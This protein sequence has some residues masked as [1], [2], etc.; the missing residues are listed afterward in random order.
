[1]RKNCLVGKGW[2]KGVLLA[3][4]LIVITLLC[5]PFGGGR[6]AAKADSE[7]A[8]APCTVHSYVVNATVNENRTIDFEEEIVFTMHENKNS[9]YRALPVEGDRF[10]NFRAEG[11]GNTAFSYDVKT[12]E[13]DNDFIDVNCYGGL[14]AGATIHY[15]FFYT[16]ECH[17]SNNGDGMRVDFV[18]GG[19]PFALNNVTVNVRFPA[20][21]TSLEI[22]SSE[23]LTAENKYVTV[24]EQTDNYVSLYAEKLPLCKNTYGNYAAPI[25][26]DF[27][28]AKGGLIPA[29]FS[30]FTRPTLWV[31]A[32]CALVAIGI[33][34]FFFIRSMKRPVLSTVV[35]FTAPDGMDP[36]ELGY[37]LDGVADN[38]D[39]TAMV[40]YFASKGYLS[41]SLDGDE[42]VL[43]RVAYIFPHTESA[44]AKVLFEGLF[45]GGRQ[46]VSVSELTNQFYV[47]SNRAKTVVAQKKQPMYEKK[48][49]LRFYLCALLSLAVF[50]LVPFLTGRLYVGKGYTAMMMPALMQ[51]LP[52]LGSTLTFWSLESYRYKFTRKKRILLMLIP[53]ALMIIGG[54]VYGVMNSNVLTVLERVLTLLAGYALLWLEMGML[55]RTE[56]HMEMLGKILGFKEFVLV[57]KKDRL[58]SILEQNPQ[59]FYDVLPFAQVMD[60][61]GVWEEKFRDIT[62]EAPRWYNG[63]AST[64]NYYHIRRSMRVI[65]RAMTSQPSKNS[66]SGR[67]GGGGVSGGFSGGGGG[68]GGGGFR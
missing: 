15:R 34:V 14:V 37:R 12:N 56:A 16:M 21:L 29:A 33:G 25:T 41:I 62:M 48:S 54:I 39:V 49:V 20:A 6:V 5:L 35:G 66:T 31:A 53:L 28:L 61:S 55:V 58:E 60:V 68:G 4:L 8:D 46:S 47:F 30:D 59:F 11:V 19:W 18:G 7:P 9:F 50:M 57:T 45:H 36:M 42:P 2:A 24:V 1:M 27:Q 64:Y 10:L 65:Q 38:D 32:V 43:H 23:F 63:H 67:S 40:Y 13:E 51:L 17:F 26:V 22:Y 3:L 52:I 44:H